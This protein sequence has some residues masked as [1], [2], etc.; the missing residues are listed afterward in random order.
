METVDVAGHVTAALVSEEVVPIG[1]VLA[2]SL[3]VDMI[4]SDWGT[5]RNRRSRGRM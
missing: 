5:G 1:V 3:Q 2:E 4:L